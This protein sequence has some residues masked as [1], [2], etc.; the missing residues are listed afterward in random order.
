MSTLEISDKINAMG[1]LSE[2]WKH[3]FSFFEKNGLPYGF[4]KVPD[5]YKAALNALPA[6]QRLKVAVNFF[7]I[8]F[9]VIYLLIL[10]LWKKALVVFGVAVLAQIIFGLLGLGVIGNGISTALMIIC[11][12]RTNA[13]YYE[14]RVL[15]KQ[16]WSL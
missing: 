15:G 3:R 10:G 13:Y 9:G 4:W 1:D 5:N 16:T 8:F 12:I 6:G 14:L 2:K 11:G 7:A